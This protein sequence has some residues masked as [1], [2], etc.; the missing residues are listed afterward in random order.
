MKRALI[1]LGALVAIAAAPAPPPATS[2]KVG[3]WNLKTD[4]LNANLG[5]GAFTAPHHVPLTRAD[6]SIVVA[7]SATGNYKQREATLSG[8]VSVHDAS[9]TFGLQ[10]AQGAQARGPATLTADELRLDDNSHLYDA[11]G[12]VHYEQG[13]TTADAQA[14][15]LND[16]THQLDLIGK[17]HTVQAD[18]TMDADRVTYNTQSGVGEASTNVLMTFPG[19]TPTFATPK[20]IKIKA[21]KIP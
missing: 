18:R 1:A 19:F 2:A 9:G 10:S 12:N 15:H 14:A 5:N 16:A 17:V 3:E 21:P 13:G 4:Q 7:D 8:H 6:G 11:K 20:P